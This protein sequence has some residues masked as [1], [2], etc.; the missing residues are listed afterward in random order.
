[1]VTFA[2]LGNEKPEP[3]KRHEDCRRPDILVAQIDHLRKLVKSN[4][5][6]MEQMQAKDRAMDRLREE[7]KIIHTNLIKRFESIEKELTSAAS[8]LNG[9]RTCYRCK[10]RPDSC[11]HSSVNA[12]Y[13][14]QMSELKGKLN[15]IGKELKLLQQDNSPSA[16]RETSQRPCKV[17]SVLESK[18][19]CK[20]YENLSH[21]CKLA[22]TKLRNL[23]LQQKETKSLLHTLEKRLERQKKERKIMLIGKLTK[24]VYLD[25]KDLP[26][27]S[28]NHDNRR[29][30]VRL[31]CKKVL[32]SLQNIKD[33]KQNN[34]SRPPSECDKS[35]SN[36]KMCSVTNS[37]VE[38]TTDVSRNPYMNIS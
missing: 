33:L 34:L 6:L 8:S 24:N 35:E 26:N 32:Q 16:E 1:M 28:Q 29:R 3:T 27:E 37:C 21:E 17:S 15:S 5:M 9:F 11:S 22:K 14:Q 23:V 38:K 20:S 31:I 30:Q 7:Q 19:H 25:E 18:A 10:R 13:D 4:H 2:D 12:L 36:G